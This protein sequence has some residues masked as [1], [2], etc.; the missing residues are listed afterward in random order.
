[1]PSIVNPVFHRLF[2]SDGWLL[3]PEDHIVLKYYTSLERITDHFFAA[4]EKFPKVSVRLLL[5]MKYFEYL[6][7]VILGGKVSL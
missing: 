7:W 2:D 1:V 3:M 5:I 4:R 6:I